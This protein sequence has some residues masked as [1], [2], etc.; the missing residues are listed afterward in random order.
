MYIFLTCVVRVCGFTMEPSS[1]VTD[2]VNSV[3]V[4]STPRVPEFNATDPEM[5]FAVMEAY[6][7]KARVVD[8]Q[9]RY[10]FV[11]SALPP[12]YAN[13]VRDII[14]RPLDD[15]SYTSLK[16]EL[17]KRL[18]SSQE[19][20][21]RKLLANVVMEDEKP[22]QYLR[23][24][25]TLAGSAVPDDLLR[26]LWMRGLPDKLKPTMATQ[27]GKP[28]SDMA[29]VADTVYSL[30]PGRLSVHEAA[31]DASLATQLQQLSL[32]FAAMKAQMS[33]LVRQISEV[34]SGERRQPRRPSRSRSQSRPRSRS[35]G[36]RPAGM[37]WYHWVHGG[38]AKKC[39]LP[40]TW[41]AENQ[42]G[43]R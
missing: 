40:C 21:T 34:S 41:N 8:N 14:M 9:Q 39:T 42:M 15:H 30:L 38:E 16:Q 31:S 26:T 33:T 36:P 10:L 11:V 4:T 13:E 22:S 20:K 17:I 27:T 1:G 12:R 5:W 23:R 19:E 25:Q 28:L 29:E 18:S 35:R 3:T 37:C 6:F 2:S 32:E 24:L 43:S 7:T